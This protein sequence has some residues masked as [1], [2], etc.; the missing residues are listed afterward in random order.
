MSYSTQTFSLILSDFISLFFPNYCLSCNLTLSR[1]E[2]LVCSHCLNDLNRTSLHLD[3]PNQLHTRFFEVP[4]L[5]YAF[6]LSWFQKGTVIQKLLHQL[7]YEGNEAVGLLLG[8]IMG[9]EIKPYFQ[10]EW[11]LITT[12][13]I[14]YKKERKR[15]YNQS[16]IIAKGFSRVL[17][18]PFTPI[19]TKTINSKSQTKKHRIERFEN[20][21][22]VFELIS[23]EQSL[24]KKKILLLDDVI[25]TGATMQSCCKPLIKAGAEISI[26]SIACT[27]K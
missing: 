13:P 24:D 14:H 9:E 8:E 3:Q 16:D 5:K 23:K 20:V 27:R 22:S 17:N 6:A 25:T 19:L 1:S 7:K 21:E 26:A 15:G 12:V 4:N 11:D 10:N 18:I 2:I